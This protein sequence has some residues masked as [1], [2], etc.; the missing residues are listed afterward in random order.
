MRT[1]QI[2][3]LRRLVFMHKKKA[4][5]ELWQNVRKAKGTNKRSRI[6]ERY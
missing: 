3:T 5:P 4:T 1:Q 6:V 2:K